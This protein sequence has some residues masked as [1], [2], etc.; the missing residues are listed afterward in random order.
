MRRNKMDEI[1]GW[2]REQ[3]GNTVFSGAMRSV[4]GAVRHHGDPAWAT[5]PEEYREAFAA[6]QVVGWNNF[7]MGC[8]AIEWREGLR[9]EYD[10]RNERKQPE[11]MVAAIITRLWETSWDLWLGRNAAVYPSQVLSA[12]GELIQVDVR[13]TSLCR[14]SRRNKEVNSSRAC[15]RRWLST[16]SRRG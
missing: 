10:S 6:Q 15:M 9:A 8:W 2:I 3:G 16:V 12:E 14:R 1:I 7:L 11:R 5:I 13:T 4:L